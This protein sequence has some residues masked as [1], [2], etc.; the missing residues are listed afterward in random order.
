[1]NATETESAIERI[2]FHS[3]QISTCHSVLSVETAINCNL[4]E[5]DPMKSTN[6]SKSQRVMVVVMTEHVTVARQSR[7]RAI[8]LAA[9]RPTCGR[10]PPWQRWLERVVS[11]V[12]DH[13]E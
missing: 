7:N 12:A 2:C 10:C 4:L 5:K 3:C 8:T 9:I 13:R 6:R 11:F 1:M